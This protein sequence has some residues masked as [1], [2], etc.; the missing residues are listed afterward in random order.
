MARASSVISVAITGDSRKLQGALKGADK[1]VSRFGSS[2]KGAALGIG[3]ALAGIFAV[4]KGFDFLQ[5]ALGE[6]D[7]LG[8]SVANLNRIIGKTNTAKLVETAGAFI[9]LGLSTA[10]VQELAVGFARIGRTIGISQHIIGRYADDV[11][12]VAQAFSLTDE[13]GRSA[14]EWV[15][16]IGKV[17]AKPSLK[18][19]KELGISLTDIDKLT[20]RIALKETGKKTAKSLTDAE[21]AAARL[22]AILIL[23]KPALDDVINNPD[24]ELKQKILGAKIEELQGQLGNGLQP[25]IA[26]I[27]QN[28][29]DISKSEWVNDMVTGLNVIQGK[30]ISKPF[31]DFKLGVLTA[32]TTFDVLKADFIAGFDEANAA[33]SEDVAQIQGWALDLIGLFGDIGTNI[34]NTEQDI[35]QFGKNVLGPLGNVRDALQ[36]ILNL[37]GGGT[38]TGGSPSGNT[39][40]HSRNPGG[41]NF[42]SDLQTSKSVQRQKERNGIAG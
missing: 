18:N 3:S 22:K 36:G 6:A 21:L 39:N 25:I 9:D 28:I 41:S 10:D 42:S 15:A 35:I 26:D 20:N 11:A 33:L 37:I 32:Q 19:A 7:R 1:G 31:E 5:G 17:A 16:I 8:D 30:E 23:T 27:L 29:L 24:V 38:S 12:A 14:A 40:L 4:S 34:F 2:M 13:K